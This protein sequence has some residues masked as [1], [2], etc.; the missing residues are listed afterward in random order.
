M[1]I[2]KWILTGLIYSGLY[3][4]VDISRANIGCCGLCLYTQQNSYSTSHLL[5]TVTM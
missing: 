5:G 4:T 2:M 3:N 1:E